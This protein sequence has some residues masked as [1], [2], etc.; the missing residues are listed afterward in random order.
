MVTHY[1][2][3]RARKLTD[4]NKGITEEDIHPYIFIFSEVNKFVDEGG[5]TTNRGP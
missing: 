3:D 5:S 2:R 4:Y 1:I